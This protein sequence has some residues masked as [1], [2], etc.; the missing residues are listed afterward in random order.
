MQSQNKNST[1]LS[2][3]LKIERITLSAMLAVIALMFTYVETLLPY[4]LGI[5]GVKLGLANLVILISLYKMNFR[6][7]FLIN[8][9]RVVLASLLFAGIFAM[10]YSFA[11]ATA[12]LIIMTLL[13]KTNKFSLIG[14]SMAGGVFHNFAQLFVAGFI[15]SNMRIFAYAPILLFSGMV[16]GILIGIATLIIKEKIPASL[17]QSQ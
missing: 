16:A 5:P 7:A 10:L 13:K 14:V 12:S 8:M 15:V 11:G 4:D 17:W 1:H 6:Y 3:R 9:I 2:S